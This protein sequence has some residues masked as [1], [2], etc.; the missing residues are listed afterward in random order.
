MSWFILFAMMQAPQ[1]DYN[2]IYTITNQAFASEQECREF[3]RDNN[4]VLKDHILTVYPLRP[5]DQVYCIRQ[6]TLNEVMKDYKRL[7][8]PLA[9]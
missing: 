5:V 8:N 2:E 7:D 9:N 3:V 6:D 4:R 1:E